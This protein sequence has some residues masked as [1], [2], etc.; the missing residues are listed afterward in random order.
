MPLFVIRFDAQ[1]SIS[2]PLIG[3]SYGLS[4]AISIGERFLQLDADNAEL[5]VTICILDTVRR[6]IPEKVIFDKFHSH[7]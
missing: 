5:H 1:F 3:T 4:V 2:G 7:P 6:W